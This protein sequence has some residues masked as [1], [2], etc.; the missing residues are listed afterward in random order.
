MKRLVVIAFILVTAGSAASRRVVRMPTLR[1]LCPAGAS[2]EKVSSCIERQ[3]QF[4]LV[5][6]EPNVK[7]IQVAGGARFSGLYLYTH[8]DNWKLQGEVHLYQDFELLS[9]GRATFG[10]HGA[11][12]IE[13]GMT[14][15]T[16][17]SLDGETNVNANFRY[18]LTNLCLDE[19][20]GCLQLTTSCDVLVHGRAYN[21]FRGKLVYEDKQLKV[22]GDRTAAG[23]Y[24]AQGELVMQD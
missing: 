15:A 4:K 2:W 9:F 17:I 12:R 18:Q 20:V 22:V 13:I 14:S 19:S 16:A 1:D 6:D 23:Q 7:L 5:R 8:G 10:K 11:Y 3:V 24:C 21:T